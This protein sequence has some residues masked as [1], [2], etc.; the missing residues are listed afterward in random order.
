MSAR[1]TPL[2]RIY[3]LWSGHCAQKLENLHE[4]FGSVVRTGPKHI[5]TSDRLAIF[6]IYDAGWRFPKSDFY[7]VF[8]LTYNGRIRDTV[9]STRNFEYHK[10]MQS[11]VAGR[12]TPNN[13]RASKAAIEDCIQVFI[14]RMT[15]MEGQSVD[16][17]N[18]SKYWAFDTNST[19]NFGHGFGFM[20]QGGDIQNIIAGNDRGFQIGALIGQA[21]W[22]NTLLLENKVLMRILAYCCGITD[23]T[24]DFVKL[25]K[26]K[27]A[28]AEA[29]QKLDSCLLT[30]LR[31]EQNNP[32]K[33]DLDDATLIIHLANYFIAGSV[34]VAT[35]IGAIIYYVIKNAAVYEKLVAEVREGHDPPGRSEHV[36][37]P[38]V[39]RMTYLQAVVK[40]A[41][42]LSPT[43]NLPLERIVPR[44]GLNINGYKIPAG[45]NVG[46]SAYVIHRDRSVYGSDAKQFRPERWLESDPSMLKQM[47]N[48][49][50]AFGRGE[51]GC[52][53][54]TLAMMMMGIFVVQVF[55]SF[56]IE[57]A[58]E[59]ESW[60]LKT[61]WM[62]EQHGLIVRFKTRV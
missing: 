4:Q 50:F 18:W 25:I 41:M 46:T 23:P 15:D 11:H 54:R 62:P 36:A 19:M 22:L 43:N 28:E 45:T 39:Q 7:R 8:A 33:Q 31:K 20:I 48:N 47:Q 30:W 3:L 61:W 12:L 32:K 58:S 56:D 38:D 44:E 51:R 59:K 6:T 5:V 10:T 57:W 13:L 49:F 27:V 40:E 14:Q 34:T 9:F 35:S 29:A 2:Y 17:S 42:R 1:L 16:L 24:A 37:Y 52:S 60:D 53:G 21:P 26:G 55:R